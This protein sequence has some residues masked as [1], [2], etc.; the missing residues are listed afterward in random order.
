MKKCNDKWT[1]EDKKKHFLVSLVLATLFPLAAVLASIGKELF[2]KMSNGNHWCWK[3]LA[4]D[5]AGIVLGTTI[6]ILHV[7]ILWWIMN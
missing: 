5:A 3:D 7:S 4:A 1:G 2:D 6:Q